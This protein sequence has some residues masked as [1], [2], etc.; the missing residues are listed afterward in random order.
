[1]QILPFPHREL[2]RANPT[3]LEPIAEK[4]NAF[5]AHLIKFDLDSNLTVSID[6]ACEVSKVNFTVLFPRPETSMAVP[7]QFPKHYHS[8]N[9]VK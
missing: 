5:A 1:M 2:S 9:M 7:E 3:V 8:I 6:N 4:L